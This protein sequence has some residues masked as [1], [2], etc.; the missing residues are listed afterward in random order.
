MGGE[1]LRQLKSA[2]N[3]FC[4]T[5]TSDKPHTILP[6]IIGREKGKCGSNSLKRSEGKRTV[7]YSS[8]AEQG[9]HSA[10]I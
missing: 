5:P 10:Q 7:F 3:P 2:E 8:Y 6:H 9:S 1:A 4:P